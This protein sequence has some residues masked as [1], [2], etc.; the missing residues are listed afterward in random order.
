MAASI[1]WPST[2]RATT[3]HVPW[4]FL[5]S[6]SIF[7]SFGNRGAERIW[8]TQIFV[9]GQYSGGEEVVTRGISGGAEASESEAM[10]QARA[11]SKTL[12][13]A[14][15]VLGAGPDHQQSRYQMKPVGR[16]GRPKRE[17]HK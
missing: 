8:S 13:R 2:S 14:G 7:T 16:N 4:S 1:C 15:R 3:F 11:G 12:V 9:G 17:Q 6:A 10:P 5:I